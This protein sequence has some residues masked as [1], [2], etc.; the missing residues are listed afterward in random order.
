MPQ[1]VKV[2]WA[3]TFLAGTGALGGTWAVNMLVRFYSDRPAPSGRDADQP[4]KQPAAQQPANPD[5]NQRGTEQF[6]FVVKTVPT[7][8]SEEEAAKDK[9]E[10]DDK[11]AADWWMVRLTAALGCIGVI[12]AA[13]FGL[14]ARRLRQTV[15]AMKDI[16]ERQSA[17]VAPFDT[18][19]E[20]AEQEPSW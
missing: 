13:V 9:A 11:S 10:R 20:L 6:P 4:P 3:V 1:W 5:L 16:D 2:A 7:P 18:D 17:S 14:Q 19:N 12:Q 8:K 15:E